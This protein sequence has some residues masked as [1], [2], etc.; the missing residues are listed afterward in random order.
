M[1]AEDRPDA[2]RRA[3]RASSAA[4][5]G[6]GTR[7]VDEAMGGEIVA[8]QHDQVGPQAIGGIDDLPDMVEPHV[9]P[10][11]VQVGDD[12]DGEPLALRPARRRHGDSASPPGPS[13]RSL[14]G[15]GRGATGADGAADRRAAEQKSAPR[16]ALPG[17]RRR[18]VF[19]PLAM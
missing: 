1:I 15:I 19:E 3:S 14:T 7:S 10:A 11:G 5:T 12:A 8:K 4:Q 6:C 2:E 16:H 18:H 9:G 17:G 13:A